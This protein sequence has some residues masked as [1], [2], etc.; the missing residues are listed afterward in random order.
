MG[1]CHYGGWEVHDLKLASWRAR[2]VPVQR[3]E[4][5]DAPAQ[6]QPGREKKPSSLSHLV[7]AHFQQTAWGPPTWGG[8]ICLP[9]SAWTQVFISSRNTLTDIPWVIFNQVSGCPMT[10]S[11]WWINWSPVPP[12][13]GRHLVP[14]WLCC[15]SRNCAP[16][17]VTP[18]ESA[19]PS[20]WLV[21]VGVTRAQP[22][23]LIWDSSKG[24]SQFY[25]SLGEQ[26]SLLL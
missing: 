25:I 22:L 7:Y 9:Q 13:R 6:R 17:K 2:E 16:L 23:T 15:L 18:P 19:A 10:Q 11:D 26:L 5:T 8:D 24:P 12:S 4:K 20:Q 1:W 21:G 14:C 3:Q